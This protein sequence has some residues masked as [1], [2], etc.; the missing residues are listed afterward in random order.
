MAMLIFVAEPS[1]RQPLLME[2][3]SKASFGELLEQALSGFEEGRLPGNL[4]DTPEAL[5]T[6]EASKS[7]AAPLTVWRTPEGRAQLLKMYAA[8]M[9]GL[10]QATALG[11]QGHRLSTADWSGL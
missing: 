8:C 6:G 4:G 1:Q 5:Y 2:M 11:A 7:S 10:I 9:R 3:Y